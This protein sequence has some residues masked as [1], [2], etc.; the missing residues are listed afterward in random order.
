MARGQEPT[1]FYIRTQGGETFYVDTLQEA[2]EV[3]ISDDGY[4]LTLKSADH[5]VVVRRAEWEDEN[6]LGKVAQAEV[7]Y[8]KQ[9]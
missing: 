8:R 6:I 9:D 7:V 3:F 5:E 2:L 1:E 4:R